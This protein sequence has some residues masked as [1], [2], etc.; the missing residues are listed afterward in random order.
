MVLHVSGTGHITGNTT[1]GG[2][3][4]IGGNGNA[5]YFSPGSTKDIVWETGDHLQFYED[6]TER[7]RI[8]NSG[9]IEIKTY[10]KGIQINNGSH[11]NRNM[12]VNNQ[13]YIG[14][15]LTDIIG[16]TSLVL[17]QKADDSE[18]SGI[19]FN[20]SVI[21]MWSP[22]DS[23]LVRFYDED[24][25]TLRGYIDGSSGNY[26]PTSDRRHKKNIKTIKSALD[27][28]SQIRGVSFTWKKSKESDKEKNDLGII[29]QEVEPIIPEVIGT[30][31]ETGYKFA[32]YNALTGVL[33]EAV[34]ELKAEKD[35]LESKI[36]ALENNLTSNND[37]ANPKFSINSK[38]VKQLEQQQKTLNL[39]KWSFII[40]VLIIIL[41]NSKKII[42]TIFPSRTKN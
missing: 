33:I 21:S 32:N 29:A 22:G 26:V 39:L 42:K 27:K 18:Y 5:L 20:G 17:E 24:G 10:D 30:D 31:E 8:N 41:L 34:K 14:G 6:G 7:M 1:I 23:Y 37:T 38:L 4:T 35:L 36:I 3:L 11:W 19:A 2:N 16:G 40:A 13:A 15:T 25:A 12:Y 28:I 9:D